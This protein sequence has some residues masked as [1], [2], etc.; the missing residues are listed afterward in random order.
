MGLPWCRR[1]AARGPTPP[2]PCPISLDSE[3]LRTDSAAGAGF[4]P[5]RQSSVPPRGIKGSSTF[6]ISGIAGREYVRLR[7]LAEA[8]SARKFNYPKGLKR[9]YAF[10]IG[11]IKVSGLLRPLI[12]TGLFKYVQKLRSQRVRIADMYVQPPSIYNLLGECIR[13][14]EIVFRRGHSTFVTA[15]EASS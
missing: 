14:P 15:F 13:V 4:Q 8:V 2:L 3:E 12:S 10:R 9:H 5:F 7:E 6:R 1:R 11:A